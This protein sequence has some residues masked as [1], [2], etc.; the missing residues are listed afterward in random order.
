MLRAQD[1]ARAT[2]KEFL[3]EIIAGKHGALDDQTIATALTRLYDIGLRPDWWKLEPQASTAAWQ[4]IDAV[5]AARDPHCRGIVMLGLEAPAADLAR[6]FKAAAKVPSV[7][8]FAVGRT[9]WSAV[10]EQWFAGR[11]SDTEAVDEMAA[12]FAELCEAWDRA[13]T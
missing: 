9:L 1:A 13:R 5:I 6:A 12:R 7:R 10:A 4:A 2:G 11:M 8:G 3:L